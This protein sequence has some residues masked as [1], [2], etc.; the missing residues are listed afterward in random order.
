MH[1]RR[2]KL[3]ERRRRRALEVGNQLQFHG[4]LLCNINLDIF[5]G[6]CQALE[7]A[8]EVP[9]SR[10]RLRLEFYIMR[11]T[12][13]SNFTSKYSRGMYTIFINPLQNGKMYVFLELLYDQSFYFR[14]F[15]YML[16]PLNFSKFCGVIQTSHWH[17]TMA[18]GAEFW[19]SCQWLDFLTSLSRSQLIQNLAPSIIT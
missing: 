15:S 3:E 16:C 2:A 8:T 11:C 18:D 13:S 9:V 17:Q 6:A 5:D 4:A 14:H 10:Y 1:R 12:W 7:L 19:I